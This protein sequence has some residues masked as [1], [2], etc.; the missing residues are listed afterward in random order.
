MTAWICA[1][2]SMFSLQFS[3][4]FAK[5]CTQLLMFW[6][7][8]RQTAVIKNNRNSNISYL[9]FHQTIPYHIIPY[10]TI[11]YKIGYDHNCHP[12][13]IFHKPSIMIHYWKLVQILSK[14]CNFDGCGGL[15]GWDGWDHT[16]LYDTKLCA[17]L[18]NSWNHTIL[19]YTKLGVTL[20]DGLDHTY[21]SVPYKAECNFN[22]WVESYNTVPYKTG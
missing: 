10:Y 14:F 16:I 22:G 21:N 11:P 7:Q 18:M 20:M 2:D 1:L 3:G 13:C 8:H 15:E 19:Y 5:L 4:H 17:T 12:C 6:T 9:I